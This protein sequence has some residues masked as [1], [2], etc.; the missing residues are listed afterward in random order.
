[1]STFCDKSDGT[2]IKSVE[3]PKE[4]SHAISPQAT[5]IKW[6]LLEEF[7]DNRTFYDHQWATNFLYLG[8]TRFD[9]ETLEVVPGLAES[10]EVNEAGDVWTFY[11][12]EDV[13]WV[14]TNQEGKQE[15]IR[16]VNADEILLA[17]ERELVR[18]IEGGPTWMFSEIVENWGKDDDFTI[19][20]EL[21]EPMD[22]FPKYASSI[23]G[24][25]I[26][27]LVDDYWICEDTP[28]GNGPFMMAEPWDQG[29]EIALERNLYFTDDIEGLPDQILFTSENQDTA[30]QKLENGE[31]DVVEITH[32]IEHNET[33]ADLVTANGRFFLVDNDK[34]DEVVAAAGF[35]G[36]LFNVRPA[37]S[38]RLSY[39]DDNPISCDNSPFT[40]EDP[41]PHENSS[42]IHAFNHG[43]YN[44]DSKESIPNPSFGDIR[45]AVESGKIVVL[46]REFC[47]GEAWVEL[48]GSSVITALNRVPNSD[49]SY[50]MCLYSTR[51][52]ESQLVTMWDMEEW[53]TPDSS[54]TQIR[55]DIYEPN[56]SHCYWATSYIGF[57]VEKIPLEMRKAL[58]LGFS[59]AK[60]LDETFGTIEGWG[61]GFVPSAYLSRYP[62]IT[63]EDMFERGLYEQLWEA[64]EWLQDSPDIH[65]FDVPVEYCDECSGSSGMARNIARIWEEN[66]DIQ[67]D[68]TPLSDDDYQAPLKDA[69]NGIRLLALTG[70]SEFDFLLD[71]VESGSVMVPEEEYENYMVMVQ[72]AALEVDKGK[73]AELILELEKLLN[74]EYV[75]L[76]PINHF[77]FCE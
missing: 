13:Y 36:L 54:S 40:Y 11:I 4:T 12:Q 45:N 16:P 25:P 64:R 39:T 60:F 31:L 65:N 56:S 3:T 27:G 51:T 68:T 43:E 52:G 46:S 30:L 70:A 53:Y 19:W 20:F 49:G 71:A 6:N 23:N 47:Y 10:W 9:P 57:D 67:F 32:P 74:R 28:I 76:I 58:A 50:N 44:E 33:F 7:C 66:L 21:N 62:E 8:L 59:K 77:E 48:I 24:R 41:P 55:I 42:V 37:Q 15:K 34:K 1:L 14:G 2:A 35:A 17:F 29:N 22:D 75:S 73:R 61:Y 26:S 69:G 38:W 72:A 63:G 5:V 18:D